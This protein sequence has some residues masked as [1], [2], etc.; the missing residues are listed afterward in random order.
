MY[1]LFTVKASLYN[2]QN[3][4][5]V[6]VKYNHGYIHYYVGSHD[7][8]D[9]FDLIIVNRGNNTEFKRWY[10][11]YPEYAY[12][13]VYGHIDSPEDPILIM[14]PY[15]PGE[16]MNGHGYTAG[17][18]MNV[19]G[20]D[21]HIALSGV[22]LTQRDAIY[23]NDH[24]GHFDEYINRVL[25]KTYDNFSISEYVNTLITPKI[26][27]LLDYDVIFK[28]FNDGIF[29]FSYDDPIVHRRYREKICTS[30]KD[31]DIYPNCTSCRA[32][33]DKQTTYCSAS[34][35]DINE[36][37][38]QYKQKKRATLEP[39]VL[40]IIQRLE[41]NKSVSDTEICVAHK[42]ILGKATPIFPATKNMV[43]RRILESV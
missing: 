40:D 8:N 24:S 21:F 5:D 10:A 1:R 16:F 36:M 37:V 39:R 29:D 41:N 19:L 32:G 38:K 28:P 17:A 42:T 11:K 31:F 43:I 7:V 22:I 3:R 12:L 9:Y 13:Y 25:V 26:A 4:D 20:I 27:R 2:N 30:G 23:F 15:N 33:T 6:C 34:P 14:M 35:G 18:A